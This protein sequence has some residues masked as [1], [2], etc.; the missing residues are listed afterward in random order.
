[1]RAARTAK[2][3]NGCARS[4]HAPVR[5]ESPSFTMSRAPH[6]RRATP[7][8]RASP[9]ISAGMRIMPPGR[10]ARREP[11][12]SRVGPSPCTC[13]PTAPSPCAKRGRTGAAP[14]S[15]AGPFVQWG[16]STSRFWGSVRAA[17]FC[18][19]VWRKAIAGLKPPGWRLPLSHGRMSC[20]AI[21]ST[22]LLR[23]VWK[24][25]LR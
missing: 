14:C 9:F 24:N 2:A 15:N 18:S 4:R 22:G 3:T 7:S 5:R 21:L 23:V 19:T 25:G 10:S 17:T 13:T 8:E 11:S 20:W 12:A 16:T 6:W 1:M